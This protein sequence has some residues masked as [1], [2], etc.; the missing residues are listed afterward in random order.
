[1]ISNYFYWFIFLIVGLLI[2]FIAGMVY[3][4]ELIKQQV[5]DVLSDTNLEINVNMNETKLVDY[6]MQ[7][8]NETILR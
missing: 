5:V 3:Q 8:F 4:Q 6:T 7:R 1:M 2:G